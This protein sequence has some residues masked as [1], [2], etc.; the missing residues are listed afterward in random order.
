[1]AKE[2]NFIIHA[3]ESTLWKLLINNGAHEVFDSGER[4]FLGFDGNTLSGEA[5]LQ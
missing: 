5:N 4:Q 3:K 1:M 2:K